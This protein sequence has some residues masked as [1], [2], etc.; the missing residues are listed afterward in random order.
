MNVAGNGLGTIARTSTIGGSEHI[1][2]SE[3]GSC[4]ERDVR[5]AL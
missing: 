5:G 1:G 4:A 2:A 3:A